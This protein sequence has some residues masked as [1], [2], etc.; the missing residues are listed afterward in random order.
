MKK[1]TDMS[2]KVKSVNPEVGKVYPICGVLSDLEIISQTEVVAK[3]NDNIFAKLIIN[4]PEHLKTLLS[5]ILDTGIFFVEVQEI[6]DEGVLSGF[7]STIIFGKR[8]VIDC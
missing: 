6:S 3:I 7:C 1:P 8:Q 5:R 2:L 4:D